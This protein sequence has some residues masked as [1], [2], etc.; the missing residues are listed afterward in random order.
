MTGPGF[1]RVIIK[2]FIDFF[3]DGGLMLAGSMSYFFMM[4][5]IPFS[6]F[7]VT[8][9]GYFI[10]EDI[11]FYHFFLSKLINFFPKITSG[12]TENLRSIIIFKGIGKFTFILYGLLSFQLFSSVESSL[13]VIFKTKQSRSFI[14]SIILALLL[15]TI[16]MAF[17]LVSFGATTA[18]SLLGTL[19]KSFPG[20]KIGTMA[21]FLIGYVVP[22]V[23]V[24]FLAATIYF[25]FPLKE[26][27]V[28]HAACGALFTAVLLEAAKHLFTIYVVKVA[29]LG[30]I[31]GPL[32][33]FVIFLLW[34]FYSSCI[35]LVGAELV[36]NLGKAKGGQRWSTT[37]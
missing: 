22:V 27:K 10:G 26:V 33:A 17:L 29:K 34:I 11:E 32:S 28:R 2:S 8:L 25:L 4:A 5:L 23:L 13:N 16:I 6:L 12:I 36:Y 14:I 35:F 24:F 9:F 18:I 3:R 30:A 15:V 20:L 1:V 37:S 19:K 31:Y 21:G 7:L